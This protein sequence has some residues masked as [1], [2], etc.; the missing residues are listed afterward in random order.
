MGSK[1]RT[2]DHQR[3][4]KAVHNQRKRCTP[5]LHS[6]TLLSEQNFASI[7]RRSFI[8]RPHAR[9][10]SPQFLADHYQDSDL[11]GYFPKDPTLKEFLI[12]GP[13]IA[14]SIQLQHAFEKSHSRTECLEMLEAYCSLGGDNGLTEDKMRVACGL[15]PRRRDADTAPGLGVD[16][17]LSQEQGDELRSQLAVI[18]N[19]LK[20]TMKP[21][22]PWHSSRTISK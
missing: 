21:I 15:A 8:W 6:H 20:N 19:Y 4:Q 12:S 14:S 9:F 16:E 13:A 10:V 22:M 3:A 1:N 5:M 11:D 7:L 2:G 17:C 18:W